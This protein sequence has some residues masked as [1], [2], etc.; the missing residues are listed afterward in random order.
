MKT[1]MAFLE[2]TIITK[3]KITHFEKAYVYMVITISI[4]SFVSLQVFKIY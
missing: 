1:M 4:V 3:H 2:S